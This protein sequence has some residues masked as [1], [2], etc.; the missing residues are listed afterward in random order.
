MTL[1]GEVSYSDKDI[2]LELNSLEARV[3]TGGKRNSR[4]NYIRI[5]AGLETGGRP[6]SG[7][8]VCFAV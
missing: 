7:S 3:V 4:A 8:I 5:I 2:R 6:R 1:T